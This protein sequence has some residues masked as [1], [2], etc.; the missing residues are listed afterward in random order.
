MVQR[1]HPIYK[2]G[3]TPDIWEFV[4]QSHACLVMDVDITDTNRT[5]PLSLKDVTELIVDSVLGVSM[6]WLLTMAILLA[7]FLLVMAPA[8][9]HYLLAHI[10]PVFDQNY[11]RYKGD[12]HFPSRVANNIRKQENEATA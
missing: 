10:S 8:V 2:K 1:I 5:I 9:H 6:R 3:R 7:V 12:T 4:H 11:F